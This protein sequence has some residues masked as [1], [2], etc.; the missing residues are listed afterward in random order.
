MNTSGFA[1]RSGNL[2]LTDYLTLAIQFRVDDP[3]FYGL[4]VL[5]SSSYEDWISYVEISSMERKDSVP[6]FSLHHKM[7]KPLTKHL[8]AKKFD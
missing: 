3:L 6:A 2:R 7:S 5:C 8:T 4:L 1:L